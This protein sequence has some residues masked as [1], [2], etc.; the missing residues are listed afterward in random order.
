MVQVQSRS[1]LL[2]RVVERQVRLCLSGVWTGWRGNFTALVNWC[3][4]ERFR[5]WEET[6]GD[7][8]WKE[9][10]ERRCESTLP[11][12]NMSKKKKRMVPNKKGRGISSNQ[13]VEFGT[14]ATER[15]NRWTFGRVLKLYLT[16]ASFI[17]DCYRGPPLDAIG[18]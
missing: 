11:L 6:R 5:K 1:R 8:E 4:P 9:E 13:Q 10:R 14:K 7:L 16:E 18:A 12:E 15:L 17:L 3:R 2:F